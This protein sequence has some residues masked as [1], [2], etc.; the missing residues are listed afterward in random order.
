MADKPEEAAAEEQAEQDKN[1]FALL[2]QLE[3]VALNGRKT[4]YE[5][6]EEILRDEKIKISP[7]LFSRFC[8]QAG[9]DTCIP[10]LLESI[11]SKKAT[12]AKIPDAFTKQLL[13]KFEKISSLPNESLR[14]VLKAAKD[15]EITIATVTSLPEESAQKIIK[16]IGLDDLDV[17]IFPFKN[18]DKT[19][20]G[21]NT[22][23]KTAR[24][25]EQKPRACAVIGGSMAICKSALSA[26]MRCAAVPDEFTEFQDYSGVDLVLES[27]ADIS[28]NEL[29]ETL[30]PDAP[31]Q[32]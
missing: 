8:L 3:D 20:P 30:F 11:G 13:T 24:E 5:T 7:P 31:E 27:L 15:Q 22:W 25:L 9:P 23:L 18:G 32:S 28:A 14:K 29:L 2:F 6:L 19:I 17:R 16:R 4:A 1:P 10:E 26:D 21:P 12:D